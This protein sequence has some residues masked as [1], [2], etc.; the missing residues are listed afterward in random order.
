MTYPPD[1]HR[2]IAAV[3]LGWAVVE[4]RG[5]NRS[6]APKGASPALPEA[7]S[8][9]PLPL[10][11]ER[12]PMEL[13]IEAQSTLTYLA[14]HL[15]VDNHPDQESFGAAID[16]AARALE[17][18]RRL[19]GPDSPSAHHAWGLLASLIWRFDAQVQDRLTA[20]SEKEGSGYQLGR[21]LAECYW[22]LDPGAAKGWSS[23]LFL[24]DKARC[25]ELAMLVG[26]LSGYL[27]TYSAAAVAGSLEVWKLV[28]GNEQWRRQASVE[29]D[30]YHQVRTWYELLVLDQDPTKLVE[31]YQLLRDW[32]GTAR[33]AT[34]FV[35][36]LLLAALGLGALLVFTFALSANP[37]ARWLEA[38]TS[39]VAVVG[40][41]TAT[42]T[43]KVKSASQALTTRLKQ[44]AYTDLII[45]SITKAPKLPSR[46]RRQQGLPTVGQAGRRRS[47]TPS[48][49]LP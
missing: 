31:P 24:F 8:D 15:G 41:S 26:R 45:E 17:R 29:N 40:L 38:L 21:G 33:A 11:I 44:D 14:R 22:A 19:D 32:R 16:H 9:D 2:V 36:Q 39:A 10:R 42:V 6:D 30:L 4:T 23:W 35:P 37:P 7:G 18:A 48:T 12:S 1:H 28:A 3:R 47:I 20:M 43:A 27:Q 5:R 49:P 46:T 34:I 13:R 25:D